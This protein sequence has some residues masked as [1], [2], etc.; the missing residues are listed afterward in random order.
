LRNYH[1]P[2]YG[3][4]KISSMAKV[5]K[6]EGR[7]SEPGIEQGKGKRLTVRKLRAA[8]DKA[9][10]RKKWETDEPREG[11]TGRPTKNVTRGG[12]GQEEWATRITLGRWLNKRKRV[13]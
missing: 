10:R 7:E 4:G 9:R 6:G 3:L 11:V 2:G 8:K 5:E 12:R 1:V 13:Y